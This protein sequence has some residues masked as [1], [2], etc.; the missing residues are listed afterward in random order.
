MT[1]EIGA[2]LLNV[3][4][5]IGGCVTTILVVYFLFGRN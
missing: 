5:I 4:E 1:L 2:N 3:I